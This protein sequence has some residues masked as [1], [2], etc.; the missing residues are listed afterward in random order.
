MITAITPTGDRQAAFAICEK[1]MQNQVTKPDQWI[2]VDDGKKP[3]IP[4]TSNMQYIRRI[5]Q[6]NEP[7]HT[8]SLNLLNVL[9]FIVGDKIIIIEDDDYYSP[10][11]ITFMSEQL[12]KYDLVGFEKARYYHLGADKYFRF[13]K[14]ID[15]S[16]LCQ[17]AFNKILIDEFIKQLKNDTTF[18]DVRFWR[19]TNCNKKLFNDD[20]KILQVGI[21]GL[22][23]REGIGAGHNPDFVKYEKD[24]NNEVLKQW[25]PN[26]FETYLEIKN[27]LN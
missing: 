17:T 4:N 11:Y 1:W 3:I 23:G 2:V 14:Q 8:L 13:D 5:P 10:D 16:S 22:P 20:N 21:K 25:I 7:Q 26:D 19:K 6:L 18:L 27:R 24:I 15:Y 12:D 9:P